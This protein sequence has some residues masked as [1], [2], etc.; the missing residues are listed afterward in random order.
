MT[1]SDEK[2][3]SSREKTRGTT[4]GRKLGRRYDESQAPAS[5]IFPLKNE[6]GK[7]RRRRLHPRRRRIPLLESL[8][9]C[10][11]MKSRERERE[12]QRR[13]DTIMKRSLILFGRVFGVNSSQLH[14]LPLLRLFVI[15]V[16]LPSFVNRSEVTKKRHLFISKCLLQFCLSFRFFQCNDD[17]KKREKQREIL[18]GY[19]KEGYNIE[20]TPLHEKKHRRKEK[21]TLL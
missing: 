18:E 1:S 13:G 15:T 19:I 4:T 6:K 10:S 3:L 12:K 5:R 9:I 2:N 17:V 20:K 21:T 8:R 14:C 16:V 7:E 11:R